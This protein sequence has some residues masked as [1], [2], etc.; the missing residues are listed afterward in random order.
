MLNVGDTAPDFSLPDQHG[1]ERR[2]SDFRG[3]KVVLY[4]YPKDNTSG[5]TT[6]AVGFRDIADKF[7]DNNAVV[8]G[9]SKDSVKSHYNFAEKYGLPFILLA[10][11][12][13]K[14]ID[15]YGVFKEKKMYGKTVM[16]VKRTTFASSSPS[17][18]RAP[19]SWSSSPPS[20]ASRASASSTPPVKAPPSVSAPFS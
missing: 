1:A 10:D 20:A 14:V 16:G 7:A 2:L 6:E 12:E 18:P 11:E 9:V 8:I 19:S 15:L 3:K 13:R 4:F 17:P 5:C